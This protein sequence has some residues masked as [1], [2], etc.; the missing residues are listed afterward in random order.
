MLKVKSKEYNLVYI[1]CNYLPKKI[2]IS[3]SELVEIDILS[4]KDYKKLILHYF[5]SELLQISKNKSCREK[6]VYY[7]TSHEIRL[8]DNKKYLQ[9]FLEVLKKL[10][11]ILPL[12]LI[13]I[14][15]S[16]ILKEK[17]GEFKE[18][19]EKI[20]NFY[21]NRKIKTRCLKKTLEV[22]EY[23]ELIKVFNNVNNLKSISV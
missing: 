11:Q 20:S 16:S 6:P 18:L 15:N 3:I 12:P 23:F 4:K 9:L 13:V 22:G 8:I 2:Y 10:K 14:E 19:N 21:V 1:D 7:L 5:L 17:N